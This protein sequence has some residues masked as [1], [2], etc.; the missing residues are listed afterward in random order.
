M[1]RSQVERILGKPTSVD[2][3]DETY[4]KLL[5]EGVV[6]QSG[7]VVGY[8]RFIDKRASTIKKPVFLEWI[9]STLYQNEK[10]QDY[11][12]FI[13]QIDGWDL[14]VCAKFWLSFFLL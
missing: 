11:E 8:I 6:G 1:S 10:Q 9:N 3:L 4:F 14:G 2:K 5:Y 12:T 13:L 7:F